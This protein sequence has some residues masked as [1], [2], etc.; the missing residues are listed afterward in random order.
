M[1]V[2]LTA[3]AAPIYQLRAATSASLPCP[4]LISTAGQCCISSRNRTADSLRLC[5]RQA[6]P[7][8][9]LPLPGLFCRHFDPKKCLEM[10]ITYQQRVSHD[11]DSIWYSKT[12]DIHAKHRW[13]KVENG[14]VERMDWQSDFEIIVSAKAVDVLSASHWRS[15]CS[16]TLTHIALTETDAH[17]HWQT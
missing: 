17:R 16:Q 4:C 10:S 7:V 2:T 14:D 8:Y 6:R 3:T 13:K 12:R 15:L 5:S 11:S 1:R 9:Y